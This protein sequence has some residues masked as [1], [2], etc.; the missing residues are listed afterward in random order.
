MN[1][2]IVH[3]SKDIA[4]E[5]E[6][7]QIEVTSID[8]PG[9]EQHIRIQGSISDEAR[10]RC[11]LA[12]PADIM[13][14]LL[15]VD[16]LRRI[17][18]AVV[19]DLVV[20]YLPYARQDRVAVPGEPLSVAVMAQ[21]INSMHCRRVTVWD[22]HSPVTLALINNVVHVEQH[23]LVKRTMKSV[24]P[25]YV[26][27]SP[28][29]GATS[30]TE[31]LGVVLVQGNKVRDPKTG[32]ITRTTISYNNI[33]EVENKSLLIVDDICDGG[34]TFLELAKVLREELRPR[35]IGLYV[36]HGIFS[37]GFAVF[38]GLVDSIFCANPFPGVGSMFL[39]ADV[40]YSTLKD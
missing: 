27:V 4:G 7:R 32:L 30:K 39:P 24:P 28:D 23:E 19:I 8:F 22:A 1:L 40:F 21:I 37:K 10:V 3:V 20:R 17:N 2:P 13:R 14:M 38:S 29:K 25:A 9:G 31:K 15:T 11:L 12:G 6:P 33:K 36:T 18:P 16:A 26:V 5:I 34:R 35:E